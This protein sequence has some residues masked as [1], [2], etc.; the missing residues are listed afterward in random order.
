MIGQVPDQYF[1]HLF[2]LFAVNKMK[3]KLFLHGP[4]FLE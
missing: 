3:K 1:D 2:L 4:L